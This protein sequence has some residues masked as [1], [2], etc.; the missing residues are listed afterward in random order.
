[1]QRVEFAEKLAEKLNRP[2]SNVFRIYSSPEYIDYYVFPASVD[3][4]G[5]YRQELGQ[6]DPVERQAIDDFSEELRTIE[7]ELVSLLQLSGTED[8]FFDRLDEIMKGYELDLRKEGMRLR[9]H[10]ERVNINFLAKHVWTAFA[11]PVRTYGP[12]AIMICPPIHLSN[13][14]QV[15]MSL[16]NYVLAE[17]FLLI[18]AFTRKDATQKKM[19]RWMTAALVLLCTTLGVIGLFIILSFRHVGPVLLRP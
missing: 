2:E 12:Y 18:S 17:N 13:V 8:A 19:L 5:T 1:M 3:I 6:F 14:P 7:A 9:R 10:G 4:E 11:I 15:S 16:A